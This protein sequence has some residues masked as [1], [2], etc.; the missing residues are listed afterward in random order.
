MKSNYYCSIHKSELNDIHLFDLFDERKELIYNGSSQI[1]DRV[2][3]MQKEFFFG[4]Y[5]FDEKKILIK[6]SKRKFNVFLDLYY[7]ELRE[8][9]ILD[10]LIKHK[11]EEYAI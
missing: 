4:Y 6:I 5:C 10:F 3:M 9:K 2:N 1:K 7:D 11:M 8:T